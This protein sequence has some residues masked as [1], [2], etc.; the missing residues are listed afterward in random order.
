MTGVAVA[1]LTVATVLLTAG[2]LFSSAGSWGLSY[3]LAPLDQQGKY[4]A[5]FR[6]AEQHGPDRRSG[7]R[8]RSCW[9]GL[10][11]MGRARDR[12]FGSRARG[13]VHHGQGKGTGEPRGHV[14]AL[15]NGGARASGTGVTCVKSWN[16]TNP[17]TGRKV[18][19]G[20]DQ[21]PMNGDPA[22]G[23]ANS[24]SEHRQSAGRSFA[25]CPPS[26]TLPHRRKVHS[27]L[28]T[29]YHCAATGSTSRIMPAWSSEPPRSPE[30]L[31][32]PGRGSRRSS[33]PIVID[34]R[35]RGGRVEC[36]QVPRGEPSR[37][38]PLRSMLARR[39]RDPVGRAGAFPVTG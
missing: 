3:G 21:G 25:L 18:G 11:R 2:E 6:F 8:C 10:C 30:V 20:R 9:R 36:S 12:L 32:L 17:G 33:A 31:P 1:V 26:P 23:K 29:R 37:G 34:G 5:S 13:P 22:L 19:G 14:K 39:R 15:P 4:L 28:Q 16:T 27:S 35:I 38:R 7:P 24:T